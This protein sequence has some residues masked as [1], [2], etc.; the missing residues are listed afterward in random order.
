M[1]DWCTCNKL[2]IAE[3]KAN[4]WDSIVKCK[5]C[6]HFHENKYKHHGI[7]V[8]DYWCSKWSEDYCCC[9]NFAIDVSPDGFCAWGERREA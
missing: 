1:S 5:D 4:C 9:G 7:A 6:V 8:I 3:A 2:R